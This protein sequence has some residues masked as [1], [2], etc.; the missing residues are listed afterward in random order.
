MS[1]DQEVINTTFRGQAVRREDKVIGKG[2][3]RAV[4]AS[5]TTDGGR[6]DETRH[7]VKI[8]NVSPVTLDNLQVRVDSGAIG[9]VLHRMIGKSEGKVGKVHILLCFDAQAPWWRRMTE[10][11][12]PW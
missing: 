5:F 8:D 9:T 7:F 12:P 4:E 1:L 10:L 2:K 3:E 11:P 6:D